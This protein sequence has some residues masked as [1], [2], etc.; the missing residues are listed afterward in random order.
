MTDPGSIQAMV[1]DLDFEI[2]DPQATNAALPD[3]PG[4]PEDPIERRFVLEAGLFDIVVEAEL[5]TLDS[6]LDRLRRVDAAVRSVESL[7][8]VTRYALFDRSEEMRKRELSSRMHRR[9]ID[10]TTG[11]M[12]PRLKRDIDSYRAR[13]DALRAAI[14]KVTT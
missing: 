13:I 14:A 6:D 9:E 1:R 2:V 11:W 8:P 10:T 7:L 4:M 5:R 12:L 3:L